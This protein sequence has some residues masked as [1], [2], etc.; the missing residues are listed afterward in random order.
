MRGKADAAAHDDAVDKTDIGL[1]IALDAAVEQIFLTPKGQ[2]P[3]MV[4]RFSLLVEQPYVA[5]GAKRTPARAGD[6]DADDGLVT[7]PFVESGGDQAHHV[8]IERVER[9]RAVEDEETRAA[10]PL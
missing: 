5:A 10:A 2:L 8:Q 3:G 4:A 9:F 6:D 1:G 7:L